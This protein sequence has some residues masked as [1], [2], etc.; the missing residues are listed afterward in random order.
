MQNYK[1]KKLISFFTLIII[2]FTLTGCTSNNSGIE[3]NKIS[4]KK[5]KSIMDFQKFNNKLYTFTK[6]SNNKL[7]IQTSSNKG[8]KWSSKELK[9]DSVDFKDATILAGAMTNNNT[10]ALYYGYTNKLGNTEGDTKEVRIFDLLGKNLS[11][12]VSSD[13]IDKVFKML[14]VN[15]DLIIITTDGNIYQ[16]SSEDG[17]LKYQYK[18]DTKETVVSACGIKDKLVIATNKNAKYYDVTKGKEMDTIKELENCVEDGVTLYSNNDN[19]IIYFYYN[20]SLYSYDFNKDKVSTITKKDEDT[21]FSDD[22]LI[23]MF[24][25]SYSNKEFVGS[26]LDLNCKNH[27]Y[28]IKIK[29]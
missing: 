7:E 15:N 26:F 2:M 9:S 6:G 22:N 20:E 19:D 24:I 18:Y 25:T 11:I 21:K 12:K 10:V 3:E 16:Y 27:L 29:K 13:E 1:I 5:V 17:S 8:K 28:N 4:F 14:F 23:P